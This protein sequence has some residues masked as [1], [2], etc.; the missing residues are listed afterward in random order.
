M[1]QK[2]TFADKTNFVDRSAIPTTQKL[3][4]V[5]TTQIKNAINANYN[6]LVLNW[7][8]D[9][10]ADY[11]LVAGQYID[12]GDVIYRIDT[13]YNVGDPKTWNAGNATLMYP[14]ASFSVMP[15]EE[16]NET[17]K[18]LATSSKIW[19]YTGSVNTTWTLDDDASGSNNELV[20]RNRGTAIWRIAK[21]GQ[22]YSFEAVDFIDVY[23]NETL[24]IKDTGTKWTQI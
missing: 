20:F 17:S 1:A 12:F 16:S 14:P 18:A 5:E 19:I 6:R 24:R 11:Q 13:G 23:P 7:D 15:A 4:G 2:I 8:N 21:T 10:I 22:L 9:I 3:S